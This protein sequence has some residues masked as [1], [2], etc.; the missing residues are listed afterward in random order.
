MPQAG[1]GRGC[2]AV[3]DMMPVT[4][5]THLRW[6]DPVAFRQAQLDDTDT[7][8]GAGPASG[9]RRGDWNRGCRGGAEFRSQA[10]AWIPTASFI[11]P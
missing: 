8:G 9:N 3:D 2:A 1:A 10:P 6:L 11:D 5:R 4:V 7:R